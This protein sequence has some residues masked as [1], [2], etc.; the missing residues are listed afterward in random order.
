[1]ASTPA[2]SEVDPEEDAGGMS[3]NAHKTGRAAENPDFAIIWSFLENFRHLLHFPNLALDDLEDGFNSHSPENGNVEII[4][5]LYKKL[6]RRLGVSVNSDKWEKSLLKVAKEH[7]L[8]CAWDLEQFGYEEL[9]VASKLELFKLLL[10]CQFDQNDKLKSSV[11]KTFDAEELRM[12][13]IGRDLDGFIYWYHED[14]SNGVR[15]YTTEEDEVSCESWRLL[16]RETDELIAVVDFLETKSVVNPKEIALVKREEMKRKGKSRVLERRKEEKKE[17]VPEEDYDDDN[18]CARCFSNVRPDSI[19]LCDKCDAAYHTACLRPPLLT[20]PQ[21]DWFCP[22]CQQLA[23]LD[24]LKEK[25]MRLAARMK[26]RQRQAKRLGFAGINLDNILQKTSDDEEEQGIRRSGRSRKNVD[27][28]FKEFE[29][30]ITS[31]VEN[32]K[33]RFKG[34]EV[35]GD[36]QHLLFSKP[37]YE[38]GNFLGTGQRNTRRSRRL[39]DLDYES[40]AESRASGYE[41]EGNSD[42]DG[43]RTTPRLP[44]LRR[45]RRIID[46]DDDENDDDGKNAAESNATEGEKGGNEEEGKDRPSEEKPENSESVEQQGNDNET[47]TKSHDE[48]AKTSE[49]EKDANKKVASPGSETEAVTADNSPSQPQNTALAGN[50]IQPHSRIASVAPVARNQPIA[51]MNNYRNL[52][53]FPPE[54]VFPN[55]PNFDLFK[56]QFPAKQAPNYVGSNFGGVNLATPNIPV[57]NFTG[58]NSGTAIAQSG[59]SFPGAQGVG[60]TNTRTGFGGPNLSGHSPVAPNFSGAN[61]TFPGTNLGGQNI[62]G[63]NFVG[64]YV[65]ELNNLGTGV[66]TTNFGG[67]NFGGGSTAGTGVGGFAAMKSPTQSVPGTFWGAQSDL[68]NLYNYQDFHLR[69]EEQQLP[70]VQPRTTRHYH[71]RTPLRPGL[72]MPISMEASTN[73]FKEMLVCRAGNFPDSSFFPATPQQPPPP[74]PSS[75]SLNANFYANNTQEGNLTGNQWTYPE[76]YGYY[77]GQGNTAGQNF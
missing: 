23:L 17:S 13:P 3:F 66:A 29:D 15:L 59:P 75:N 68:N 14:E 37:A 9:K 45:T 11:N 26:L 24:I 34:E 5:E 43:Q 71:H 50:K 76:G 40:D 56:P 20:V 27:Y 8:D 28:T 39:M 65:G 69:R 57:N 16:A 4:E 51:D 54:G 49:D 32:D 36:E 38:T 7:N 22:Y 55:P 64:P 44:H 33:K 46:E 25:K 2:S 74:Y 41:Y 77:P 42:E 72:R 35:N 61:L 31:A 63:T 67:T 10:E 30:D 58:N 18:P 62:S 12:Q 70:S 73:S 1:M 19:L 53:S 21:G 48:E 52:A 47:V 6:L 60:T